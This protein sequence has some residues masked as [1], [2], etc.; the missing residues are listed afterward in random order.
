MPETQSTRRLKWLL[1]VLLLW[2][3]AIF[4]RLV[5]LQVIRHDDLLRLAQQQQQKVVEVPAMRGSIFDRSGQPLAKSLPAE[6]ISVNPQRIPDPGVA[7]DLLSGILGM[8][9]DKLFTRI[10]T[11]KR[12]GAGFLWVKRKVDSSEAARLRTFN[13]DWVEFRDETR[14]F[15]PRGDLVSHVVGSTGIVDDEVVER[16]NAGIETPKPCWHRRPNNG[17]R[18]RH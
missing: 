3:A 18:Q 8:D 2:I 13:F 9:R 12:R 5:W 15:Y 17:S 4:T 14:R 11:A 7:A 1:R 10:Q 6:S 16:G